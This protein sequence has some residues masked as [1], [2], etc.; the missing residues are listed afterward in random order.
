MKT[1]AQ[2]G[3]GLNVNVQKCTRFLN[4][5]SFCLINEIF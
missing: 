2:D 5:N 1:T 3:G 4:L